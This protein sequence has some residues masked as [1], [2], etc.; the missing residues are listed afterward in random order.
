MDLTARF[1]REVTETEHRTDL[2][3][4]PKA[5]PIIHIARVCCAAIAVL[6]LPLAVIFILTPI[7]ACSAIFTVSFSRPA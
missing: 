6:P 4:D 3:N 1:T 7:Q 2:T 5:T